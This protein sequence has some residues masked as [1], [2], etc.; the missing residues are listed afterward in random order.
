[1][2][3]L[4]EIVEIE[5]MPKVGLIA[6]KMLSTLNA[7]CCYAQGKIPGG[8]YFGLDKG[9]DT[10]SGSKKKTMLKIIEVNQ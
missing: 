2:V 10:D 5:Y 9:S 6:W 1:M 7:F 3:L 8:P 4:L